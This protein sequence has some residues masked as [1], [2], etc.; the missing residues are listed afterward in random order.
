MDPNCVNTPKLYTTDCLYDSILLA[1]FLLERNIKSVATL[2]SSPLV[3]AA[4]LHCNQDVFLT[5]Q[6]G[7]WHNGSNKWS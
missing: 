5:S 7:N 6:R 4:Q 3:N 1:N 2:K